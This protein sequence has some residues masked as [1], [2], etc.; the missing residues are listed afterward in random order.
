MA[1]QSSG[2]G[3]RQTF[4][5]INITP[6]T[7]VFLVLL[8]IMMIVAPLLD[9]QSALK[10][11]PPKASS[12]Q[13][14][15][16]DNVASLLIEVDSDGT[17]AVNGNVMADPSTPAQELRTLAYRELSEAAST[18]SEGSRKPLVKLSADDNVGYG[19][20]IA[21]LDGINR[22]QSEGR[23]GKLSLVTTLPA[24]QE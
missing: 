2:G 5:E 12:A 21:V 15:N 1:M 8:V 22:A 18:V 14:S 19:R 16:S 11:D 17:V 7:D 20:V 6:L 24:A 23:V 3:R 4:S 10:I 13:T 9:H